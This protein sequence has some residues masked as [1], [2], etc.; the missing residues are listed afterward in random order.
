VAAL[1]FLIIHADG[2]RTALC[3]LPLLYPAVIC[4]LAAD[5]EPAKQS[6]ELST[7]VCNF[8]RALGPHVQPC[9]AAD[10]SHGADGVASCRECNDPQS[11]QVLVVVAAGP[12]PQ[13][14][15]IPDIGW[16]TAGKENRRVLPVFKE[17][18]HPEQVLPAALQSFNAAFWKDS[19]TELVTTVL[20][21]AGLTPESHRIFISYRRL[22]T[23]PLAEDLFESLNRL[24]F[25]VFLDRF[26]VPPAVNFQR[27]LHQDLAEKSMV[28]LLESDRF[29]ESKWTT[30]EITYCKRNE[31]GLYSLKLPHGMD[32]KVARTLPDVLEEW[33]DDLS[34]KDFDAAPVVVKDGT[35]EFMQWGRLTPVARDRITIEVRRRH[36]A[37][38]LNRRQNLR[39]Q[40]LTELG[41]NGARTAEMRADGLLAV[42]SKKNTQY[43]VW[44][45]P[46]PP[47]LPD[48]HAAHA[49][50]QFPANTV[51]VVVG[52]GL[53]NL[54]DPE[55]VRRL[56]WLSGICKLVLVDQGLIV[57]A[58]QKIAEGL[59]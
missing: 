6:Q 8:L 52:V 47:E 33:R 37:A 29:G 41:R 56:T 9:D 26:A 18:E 22:E 19:A 11:V 55:T 57:S 51:G 59:L 17:D 35:N 5:G 32:P 25:D 30:E 53:S 2:T 3:G 39:N 14:P 7:A 45:T 28:L 1:S 24:G 43:V 40:M 38:L 20:S 34:E 21:A 46:R 10:C 23:Q 36:D 27:R 50:C 42:T 4:F 16:W 49:G 15:T 12:P 44:I 31:L 54:L 13:M 48:F 58:S